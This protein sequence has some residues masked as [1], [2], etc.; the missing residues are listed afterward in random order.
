MALQAKN[1]SMIQYGSPVHHPVK[2]FSFFRIVSGFVFCLILAVM[3]ALAATA[4]SQSSCLTDDCRTSNTPNAGSAGA[5]GSSSIIGAMGDAGAGGAA[6]IAAAPC[7]ANADCD[8]T[9]GLFCVAGTCRLACASHYDCQGFG[10]CLGNTDSDGTSGYFCDLG[11]PQPSGEFYTHCPNGD[12]DCATDQGF[13]CIGAGA[14]D[15]EAYCTTDC[16]TDKDCADGFACM[17]LLRSPCADACN[18]AGV[19]KDRQCVPV[20][21]IGPGKAYQCGARGPTRNVCRPRKF[22]STCQTD[23]DCFAVSNQVC[24]KD[25][26]GTKICTQLCD[27][28]HPSCPWGNAGTCGVWDKALG[29]ATCAHKFGKC[30]GTGQSCEPC[31][32]DADCGTGNA[33]TASEFTGEHWCVDLS[34]ACSCASS[35]DGSGTCSGGGCPLSP[36]GIDLQCVDTSTTGSPGYCDGAD[37]V[38]AFSG[39]A[40]IGCWPAN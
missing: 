15:L 25:Q 7:S 5:A 34:A 36:S 17:P 27:T 33:C 20:T 30:V 12:A 11:Q 39:N 18:V 29:V 21:Q 9:D 37:V 1:P 14:D 10:E 3:C 4:C 19:P 16:S 35:T 24:A 8:A 28:K 23:A 26:S 31:L 13:L 6:S 38:A 32:Q 40:Q 22:C 2:S